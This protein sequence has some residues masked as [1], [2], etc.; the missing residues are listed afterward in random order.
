MADILGRP[1]SLAYGNAKQAA[2]NTI[3]ARGRIWR[4]E[5]QKSISLD[6]LLNELIAMLREGAT[7]D[8]NGRVN[9][10]LTDAPTGYPQIDHDW[11]LA[12]ARWN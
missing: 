8:K 5:P 3:L 4:R 12:R 6:D 9:Y 2:K 10:G 7:V 11:L 1:L